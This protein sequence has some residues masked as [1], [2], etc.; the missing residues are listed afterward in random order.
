MFV[1]VLRDQQSLLVIRELHLRAQHVHARRGSSVVLVFG[2]LV[3]SIRVGHPRLGGIGACRGGLGVEI[4]A[5]NGTDDEIARILVIHFAGIQGALAGLQSA[6]TLKID[7]VLL[8]IEAEIIIGKR[9]N[10][11][12]EAGDRDSEGAQRAVLQVG[13]ALHAHPRKQRGR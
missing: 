11:L 1:L 12:G 3:Q 13:V 4:E 5:G 10:H 6:I 7:D 9:S 2:E 8:R